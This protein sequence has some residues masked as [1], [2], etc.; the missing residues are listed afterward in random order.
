MFMSVFRMGEVNV[1]VKNPI[2]TQAMP[3]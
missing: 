2:V 3:C 1:N